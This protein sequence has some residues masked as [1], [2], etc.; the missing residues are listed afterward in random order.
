MNEQEL[1]ALLRSH[2][3]PLHIWGTGEAKTFDHLLSEIQDGEA[4]VVEEDGKLLRSAEGA[5]LIVF[6]KDGAR[7]LRLKEDRQVFKDGRE[8]YRDLETSIGEKMRP[9]EAA[10]EAAYRALREELDVTERLEL[11]PKPA[12]IK[13]PLPSQSFPGLM[14]RYAMHVF[15][16]FLPKHHFKPEG[17]VEVQKDKTNY[18]IWVETT[19]PAHS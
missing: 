3:I 10:V 19:T 7:T 14:T 18:Y 8:K 2:H 12:I 6:Y 13:G 17:Y 4:E 9:S 16:V 11:I 1:L 5:V 15:E